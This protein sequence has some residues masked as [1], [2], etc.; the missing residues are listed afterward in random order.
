MGATHLVLIGT[1]ALTGGQAA[2]QTPEPSQSGRPETELVAPG[3]D[4][5]RQIFQAPHPDRSS[6]TFAGQLPEKSAE[7]QDMQPRVVCGMVLVPV[8]PDADPKMIVRPKDDP[9]PEYKIRKIVP[10]MCNE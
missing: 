5:Y 7:K 2:G 1:L 4:P 8:N 9:Q 3:K 6:R 10:R